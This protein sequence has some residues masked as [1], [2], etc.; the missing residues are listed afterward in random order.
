MK[1][2]SLDHLLIYRQTCT[3]IVFNNNKS[4]ATIVCKLSRSS[5]KGKCNSCKD[6]KCGHL[7]PWNKDFGSSLLP[8]KA[9]NER[10]DDLEE[11]SEV[12]DDEEIKV[13]NRA[14][15]K[16]PLTETTQAL[17]RE[18]DSNFYDEKEVFADL[19][20]LGQKCSSHGN[21]WSDENPVEMDWCFSVQ[22]KIAHTSFA[23]QRERK[24]YFRKV[25]K[26]DCKLLYEG[27]ENF[28]VRVGGS[29]QTKYHVRAVSLVSYGLLID[30]TFDFMENGQTING[31]YNSYKAKCEKKFGMKS[32]DII[33]LKS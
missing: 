33:S 29:K 16:F 5:T 9:A 22:V 31:F 28:L 14:T 24:V 2:F 3:S 23:K 4:Y 19:P 7:T 1:W 27:D 17:F 26:C 11:D 18:Y 20:I 25:V 12:Q 30:F 32:D 21:E 6:A 10:G 15:L 8:D 13:L